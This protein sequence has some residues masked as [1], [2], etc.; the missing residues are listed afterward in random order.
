[1]HLLFVISG[2]PDEIPLYPVNMLGNA[3][4][5]DNVLHHMIGDTIESGSGKSGSSRLI[6]ELGLPNC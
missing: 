1:M 2:A 3:F 4:R 5:D 6:Q